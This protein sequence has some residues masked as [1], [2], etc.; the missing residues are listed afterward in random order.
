MNAEKKFCLGV[1][2]ICLPYLCIALDYDFGKLSD[3]GPGFFPVLLGCGGIL[4]AL[5]IIIQPNRTHDLGSGN[6][7]AIENSLSNRKVMHYLLSV[8]ACTLVFS[9]LGAILSIILLVTALAKISEVQGWKVPLLMGI[10]TAIVL[11]V[12]FS[13]WLKITLPSGLLG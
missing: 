10:V 3:P 6:D 12:V 11:Q 4:L 13:H 8:F 5:S 2:F 7:Q 1:L 9:F